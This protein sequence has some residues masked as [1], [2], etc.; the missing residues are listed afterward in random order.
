MSTEEIYA[1]AFL[2]LSEVE[3]KTARKYSLRRDVLKMGPTGFPFEQFIAKLLE[4]KGYK[5]K[6][7]V[8]LGGKCVEHEID[9][10]AYDND[11]LILAEVKFHNDLHLKTDT[12]VALYVKA[13]YDDLSKAQFSIDG[14]TR[15]MTNGTLI[16]NTKFTSNAKKYAKC[17]DM[18]LISWDYPEKGNLYDLIDESGIDPVEFAQQVKVK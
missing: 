18:G 10:M 3:K 7:G 8:T 1:K 15:D 11:D 16:T 2:Y 6:T 12:K 14:E 4:S 5:T 9:V 17:V 13:R